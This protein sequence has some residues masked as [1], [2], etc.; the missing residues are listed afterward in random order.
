MPGR[1]LL[2][3]SPQLKQSLISMAMFSQLEQPL[4]ELQLG[5]AS[6]LLLLLIAA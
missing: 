1:S 6:L 4:S 2:S 3:L 5:L